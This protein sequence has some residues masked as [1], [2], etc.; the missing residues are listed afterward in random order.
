M[1]KMIFMGSRT[2]GKT[3]GAGSFLSVKLV[4]LNSVLRPEATV[5]VSRKFAEALSL[6]GE[7]TSGYTLI[8]LI[9]ILDFF[10]KTCILR[11]WNQRHF[12]QIL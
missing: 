2:S 7:R 1:F 11:V 12:F 6:G 10:Q 9:L 8:L 4:D 3:K 5:I